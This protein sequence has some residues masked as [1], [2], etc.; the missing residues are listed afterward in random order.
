M[1]LIITALIIN[2]IS[3][4]LSMGT[5]DGGAVVKVLRYKSEGRWNFSLT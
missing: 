2:Y 5:A 1:H 3:T 4:V